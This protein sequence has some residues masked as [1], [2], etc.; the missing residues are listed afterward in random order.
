MSF[1]LTFLKFSSGNPTPDEIQAALEYD[2]EASQEEQQII[3]Q[4]AEGL[5]VTDS[6]ATWGWSQHGMSDGAWLSGEL[7][8]DMDFSARSIFISSRPDPRDP[9]QLALYTKLHEFLLQRGYV[10]FDHQRDV[11]IE[12]PFN[13]G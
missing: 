13:F 6:G 2:G 8:P 12:V 10:C 3:R 5:V 11:L 9:V 1:D 7:L 4:I